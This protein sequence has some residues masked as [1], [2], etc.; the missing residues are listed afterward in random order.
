MTPDHIVDLGV[1]LGVSL[2]FLYFYTLIF[3]DGSIL[4]CQMIKKKNW[5]KKWSSCQSAVKTL[6]GWPT[7]GIL[8]ILLAQL[9]YF[10]NLSNSSIKK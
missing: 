9:K 3:G 2:D 4:T 7:T 6:T 5:D 1:K 8:T 10:S